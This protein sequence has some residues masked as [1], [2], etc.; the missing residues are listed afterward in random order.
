MDPLS[1]Y[2]LLTASDIL[3]LFVLEGPWIPRDRVL[4]YL[5]RATPGASVRTATSLHRLFE[6]LKLMQDADAILSDSQDLIE[7][8][9]LRLDEVREVVLRDLLGEQPLPLGREKT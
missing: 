6:R 3:H 4:E 5:V 2:R 1:T 9:E 7:R 8:H